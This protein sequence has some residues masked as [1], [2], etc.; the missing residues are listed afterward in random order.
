M[1]EIPK[2]TL[3]LTS[4]DGEVKFSPYAFCL[5]AQGGDVTF[6]TLLENY[7]GENA[8]AAQAEDGTLGEGKRL[9]GRYVTIEVDSG[10]LLCYEKDNI[11]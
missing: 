4:S 8:V 9:Y 11:N 1:N 7:G 6:T 2:R 3:I 10:T 5:E